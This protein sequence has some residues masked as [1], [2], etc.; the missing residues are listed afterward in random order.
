MRACRDCHSL[1]EG[2]ACPACKSTNLSKDW[3]GYV[4]VL[5]PKQ[6]IIAQKMNIDTAGKYAL[7]VR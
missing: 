6:S 2:D 1:A 3:T 5:D 7:K 4:V